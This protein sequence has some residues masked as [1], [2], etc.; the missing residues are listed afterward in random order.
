MWD[1]DPQHQVDVTSYSAGVY[2][3]RNEDHVMLTHVFVK[4][5]DHVEIGGV[6]EANGRPVIPT[7]SL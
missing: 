7:D 1:I 6:Y 5:P 3:M 2:A 4:T